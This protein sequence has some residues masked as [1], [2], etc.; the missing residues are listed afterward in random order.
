MS[1]GGGRGWEGMETRL[2]DGCG[3][4]L[5]RLSPSRKVRW[6]MRP[7]VPS[8]ME[9]EKAKARKSRW[10]ERGRMSV[11][12]SGMPGGKGRSRSEVVTCC[13]AERSSLS[14]EVF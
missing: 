11:L 8:P 10:L 12:Q 14:A 2:G 13:I 4:R 9:W 7:V 3:E 6:K 5:V 1:N